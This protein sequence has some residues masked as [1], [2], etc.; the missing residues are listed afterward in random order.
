MTATAPLL[1]KAHAA[2]AQLGVR[3]AGGLS[4]PSELDDG[5]RT[6]YDW[7]LHNHELAQL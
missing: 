3:D 6:T 1:F 5:I 7:F 4:I 2:S